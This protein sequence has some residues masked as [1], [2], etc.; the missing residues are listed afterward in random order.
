M[1]SGCACPPE[2]TV[3]IEA[4][5]LIRVAIRAAVDV[6][7]VDQHL[8]RG[9][10]DVGDVGY[11][12]EAD[13][14]LDA[15][16][17]VVDDGRREL[18]DVPHAGRRGRQ[19]VVQQSG[20]RRVEQVVRVEDRRQLDQVED[21]VVR[22]PVVEHTP[23]TTDRRLA[24]AGHVPGEPDAGCDLEGRF[25]LRRSVEGLHAV[26]EGARC[27]QR[28]RHDPADIDASLDLPGTGFCARRPCAVDTGR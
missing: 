28:L 23:A 11:E 27:I 12:L 3:G 9:V 25:L 7:V 24:V 5:R 21:V 2:T 14:P 13:F 1:G 19:R 26:E 6:P 20:K 22:V 16:A 10:A 8:T 18:V 15:E 17:P 4:R